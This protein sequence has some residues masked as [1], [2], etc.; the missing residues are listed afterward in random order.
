MTDLAEDRGAL[1]LFGVTQREFWVGCRVGGVVSALVTL[2]FN[3]SRAFSG[4]SEE[5]PGSRRESFS[6]FGA[7]RTLE[8]WKGDGRARRRAVV[9]VPNETSPF[10][11]LAAIRARRLST[12]SES[13]SF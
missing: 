4:C 7:Q 8:S 9:V 11:S 1:R 5:L 13:V 2:F 3:N 6:R 12:R 10:R